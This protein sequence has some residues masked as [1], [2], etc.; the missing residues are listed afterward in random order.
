M[1]A[2]LRQADPDGV[3]QPVQQER[4]DADGALDPAIFPVACLG[5]PQVQWVVPVRP[6]LIKR[7]NQQTVGLNHHLRIRRLHGENEVVE[8][9]LSGDPGKFQGALH[10]AVGRVPVTVHDP[11]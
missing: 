2:V 1:D 11:V 7:G 8:V 9:H 3:A 6:F 10:H 4:T 5:H